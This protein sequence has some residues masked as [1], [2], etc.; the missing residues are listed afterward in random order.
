METSIP[1]I[2]GNELGSYISDTHSHKL[3]YNAR[4]SR[5]RYMQVV[6]SK[7]LQKIE[8]ESSNKQNINEKKNTIS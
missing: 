2:V 1:L 6:F 5:F 8:K 4:T 3:S 7:S